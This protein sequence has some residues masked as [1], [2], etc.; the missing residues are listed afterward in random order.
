MTL[1][2]GEM[3]IIDYECLDLIQQMEGHLLR[4]HNPTTW[5]WRSIQKHTLVNDTVPTNT[6]PNN[7]LVKLVR[8][9]YDIS[10]LDIS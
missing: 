4:V 7:I 2:S 10:R 6:I 9:I 1:V 8:P 3:D 5:H